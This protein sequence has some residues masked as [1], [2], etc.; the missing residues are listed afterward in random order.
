MA[1]NI[2][3]L[4]TLKMVRRHLAGLSEQNR[5]SLQLVL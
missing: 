5:E 4:E 3:Q 1:Y 2:E